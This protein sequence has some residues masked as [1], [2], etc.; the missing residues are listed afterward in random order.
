[1]PP[2]R[3]RK[4]DLADATVEHCRTLKGTGHT[5]LAG[6]VH[7]KVPDLVWSRASYPNHPGEIACR[8]ELGEES[9]SVAVLTD[10]VPDTCAGA[11][12][13]GALKEA[14]DV[15][16]PPMAHCDTGR[17]IEPRPAEPPRPDHVTMLCVQLC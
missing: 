6:R 17:S 13:P 4:R 5:D 10:Q 8:I 7:G 2:L 12:I 16:V 14:A 11:E 9:I 1:V 3:A 15:E